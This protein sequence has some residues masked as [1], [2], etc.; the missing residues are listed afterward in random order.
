MSTTRQDAA[1][2]SAEEKITLY[3]NAALFLR[4]PDINLK[5]GVWNNS[6]QDERG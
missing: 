4:T 6:L 1:I 3:N 2:V 5:F